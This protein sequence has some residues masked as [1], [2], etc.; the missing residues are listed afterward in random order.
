MVHTDHQ[1]LVQLTTKP[2]C[3]IS[4]RLQRLLLKVTQYNFTI[5]YVKHDGVPVADC[6]SQNVQIESALD[7]ESINVIVT[8]I[9]MFQTGK[10]NQ[11]KQ[12]SKDATLVKLAKVIQTGWPDQ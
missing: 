4:P 5:M 3:E 2:L 7:D 10:I 6:L 9:S 1:P 12:T 11:I 8:A